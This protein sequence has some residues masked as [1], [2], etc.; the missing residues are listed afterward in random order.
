M[1]VYS[2]VENIPAIRF[3]TCLFCEKVLKTDLFVLIT[4]ILGKI[5]FCYA[6]RNKLCPV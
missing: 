2:V 1:I 5:A 6:S 4:G 3:C